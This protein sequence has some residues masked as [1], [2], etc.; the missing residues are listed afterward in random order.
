[1]T[2]FIKNLG[3]LN[4]QI[5]FWPTICKNIANW[6]YLVIKNSFG[7]SMVSKCFFLCIIQIMKFN[8]LISWLEDLVVLIPRKFHSFNALQRFKYQAVSICTND[9]SIFIVSLHVNTNICCKNRF[10]WS[11]LIQRKNKSYH[12]GD[13]EPFF[14][15]YFLIYLE[16][17]WF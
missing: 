8:Y 1:M 17:H 10:S 15:T 2:S 9:T 4:S 7:L 14:F 12:K 3:H 6:I 13:R 5:C 11:L 16:N